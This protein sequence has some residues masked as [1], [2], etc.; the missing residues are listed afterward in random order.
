MNS[1]DKIYFEDFRKK[2][3]YEKAVNLIEKI[4][5]TGVCNTKE[6][7][8]LL[9]STI[10]IATEIALAVGSILSNERRD[11]HY[12][13]AIGQ[14]YNLSKLFAETQYEDFDDCNQLIEEIIKLLNK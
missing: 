1:Y 14:A 8:H 9:K 7:A 6:K 11:F 13:V 12:K 5:R 10:R 3:A 4:S 2:Y